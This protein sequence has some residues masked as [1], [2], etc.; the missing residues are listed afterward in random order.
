MLAVKIICTAALIRL[1]QGQ[2]FV[3]CIDNL[4]SD[5][6]HVELEGDCD[7]TCK[8]AGYEYAFWSVIDKECRCGTTPPKT[9]MYNIAQNEYGLCLPYDYSVSKIHVPFEFHI[10]AKTIEI[11][12]TSNVQAR[13]TIV[14]AMS[15]CFDSCLEAEYVA[16][17]PQWAKPTYICKCGGMPIS[18][19]PLT[20][21]EG[22]YYGFTNPS[23]KG[24][25]QGGSD[26]K[27]KHR[28]QRMGKQT[29]QEGAIQNK[30]VD[31]PGR[32]GGGL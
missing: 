10:C 30:I 23:S 8:K 9:F 31:K 1:V 5:T 29:V 27:Q 19:A 16:I 11:S 21:G 17:A 20:C 14:N 26:R 15:E 28:P 2:A 32:Y 4:P 13:E 3:G 25:K 24:K 12:S 6:S 22:T 7:S 18:Y